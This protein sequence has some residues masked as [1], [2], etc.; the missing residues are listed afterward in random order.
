MVIKSDAARAHRDEADQVGF[1]VL[2][3]ADSLAA[4]EIDGR[5]NDFSNL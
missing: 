5:D 1:V 4:Q 2:W 3:C